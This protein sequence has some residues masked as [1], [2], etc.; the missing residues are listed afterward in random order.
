MSASGDRRALIRRLERAKGWEVKT[1]KGGHMK[2]F[3]PDGR[4]VTVLGSNGSRGSS[5]D[6]AASMRTIRKAGLDL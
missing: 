3:G 5:G 4:L 1:G 6:L 2:V